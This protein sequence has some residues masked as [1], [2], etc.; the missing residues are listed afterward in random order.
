M[1]P[2]VEHLEPK[3]IIKTLTVLYYAFIAAPLLFSFTILATI[4]DYKVFDQTNFE[5]FYYA[6]PF[7]AVGLIYIGLAIFKSQ[8]SKIKAE[9]SLSQKLSQFQSAT[10]IKTALM[11]GPALLCVVAS[12]LSQQLIF[13]IIA[14]CIIIFMYIVRPTKEHIIN[15]LSLSPRERTQ[16]N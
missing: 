2:S 10:I 14:W 12:L 15:D 11:E 7:L 5:T 3:N 1:K 9:S 8:V 16:L 13:I 4:K 6:I